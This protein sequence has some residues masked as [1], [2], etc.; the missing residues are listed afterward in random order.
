MRGASE[1]VLIQGAQVSEAPGPTP[2]H[3]AKG[4]VLV[5]GPTPSRQGVAEQVF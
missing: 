2:W 4:Q 3:N 5:R 1:H